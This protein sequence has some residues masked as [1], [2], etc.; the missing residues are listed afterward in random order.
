MKRHVALLV[1]FALLLVSAAAMPAAGAKRTWTVTVGGDTQDMAI[2]FNAFF[3]RTVEVA[4]G[5]TVTWEFR[6]FHN[7]AFPGGTRLPSL[8]VMDG[9]RTAFNPQVLFPAGSR[10]FDGMGYRNSGIPLEPGKPFSYSLTFT[11]AG[12]YTYACI[13]HPGMTGKIVVGSKA[14]ASPAAVAQRARQEMNAALAAGQSAWKKFTT[15]KMG[16]EVVVPLTGDLQSRYSIFRFT[17]Q[18]LRVPVGTTVTWAMQ[19]AFEIHTVT[20]MSGRKPLDFV[21]V[22]PQSQGPPKFVMNPKAAAP[23]GGKSYDGTG[24]VN[25]G[26]LFPPGAPPNLP[27][28]YSLTFLKAGTY[29]YWCLVH[30][31]EGMKGTIIVE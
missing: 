19:D 31:A 9:A 3:P 25:S 16:G 27:K 18:P 11:K 17:P 6:G 30:V 29:E 20:F 1:G 8:E 12:T 22:E 14:A 4:V 15:K 23:A 2:V 13:V 10:T 24:Y 26:L 28:N 21:M 7:V 5:D